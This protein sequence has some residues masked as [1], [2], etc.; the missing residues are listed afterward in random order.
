VSKY[1]E[2]KI[3]LTVYYVGFRGKKTFRL[4]SGQLEGLKQCEKI[5]KIDEGERGL[6]IFLCL[7]F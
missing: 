6:Q 7:N 5:F 1:E 2:W 3:L 4:C